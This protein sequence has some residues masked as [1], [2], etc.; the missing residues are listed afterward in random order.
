M[1][2]G[3][4]AFDDQAGVGEGEYTNQ[5]QAFITGLAEPVSGR[6][7]ATVR[8]VPDPTFDCSDIIGKVYDDRNANGYP[9]EGEPGIVGA[10]IGRR[11]ALREKSA[12]GAYARQ[13]G[14]QPLHMPISRS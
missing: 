8:V 14:V 10:R 2:L 1:G 11:R 13:A 12:P 6:A 9:D 5:A 4:P 7:T 3:S